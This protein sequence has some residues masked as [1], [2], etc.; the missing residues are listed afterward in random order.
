MEKKIFKVNRKYMRVVL[1]FLK[2]TRLLPLWQEYFY[3]QVKIGRKFTEKHWSDVR[4]VDHVLGYTTFTKFVADRL[5]KIDGVTY[6][7]GIPIYQRFA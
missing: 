1:R 2:E 5:S 3:L 4:Y 7:N 6:Y